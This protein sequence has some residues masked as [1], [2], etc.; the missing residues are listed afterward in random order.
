VAKGPG[1]VLPDPDGI[2]ERW[3]LAPLPPAE[4]LEGGHKNTLLRCGNVVLRVEQRDPESIAWEHELTTFLSHDVPGV[5]A[6]LAALDGSTFAEMD[7]IVVSVL[8]F[9]EGTPLDRDDEAQR[10]EVARLLARLHWVGRVWKRA[11]PDRPAFADLD[12]EVNAWWD[13]RIFE[14]PPVLARAYERSRTWLAAAPKLGRG[15][16]HGDFYRGNL[17]VRDSRIR[18]VLDWEDARVDWPAWELANATWEFCKDEGSDWLDP[19]RSA[20]FLDA[21]AEAE[22]PGELGPF[23]DLLR[24]RLVADALYSLT[25]AERGEPWSPQY[26]GHLLRALERCDD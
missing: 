11:R 17:R 8:P 18:G 22:G 24:L 3:G 6:P 2:A 13:V 16:V 1:T 21:Y 9:V 19:D 23:D 10:L 25:S 5:V 4:P 14:M 12:L 20:R 15:A 7:G 26:L